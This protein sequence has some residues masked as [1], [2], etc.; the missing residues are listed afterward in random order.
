VARDEITSTASAAQVERVLAEWRVA[1][2][3]LEPRP[4]RL[5]SAVAIAGRLVQD[6]YQASAARHGLSAPDFFLLA[7]LRR[8]GRPFEAT[9]GELTQVLVRSTGGTTKQ[10][11][12][13]AAAG[14]IT[15]IPNPKDRRS[16][17]VRLTNRGRHLIDA[18]LQDHLEA[19][20]VLTDGI[21]PADIEPCIDVLWTL[22]DRL[23]N[24]TLAQTATDSRPR[25]RTA[26][27]GVGFPS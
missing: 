12:R 8:R 24:W 19:E 3:D 13:L 21:D 23:R 5:F 22:V 14:H 25:T 4:F 11:D 16:N 18:A 7:E 2:P 27:G 1:R 15:R 26:P 10:L 9:P 17:I 6:F 20:T